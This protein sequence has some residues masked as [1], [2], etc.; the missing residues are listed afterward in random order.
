MINEPV[1]LTIHLESFE[2]PLD[3]LLHLIKELKIDIFDIPM[4][5]I[6]E[7][8][9]HYLHTMQELQLD[10]AGDYLLMAATLLEIK[11][12]MLLP[13]KELEIE[14]DFYEEGED[15]RE[16]LVNQ[17]LEY[18]R[19][20]E[21][22]KLLKEMEAERGDFFTKLPTDLEEYRHSIP[23]TPGEVSAPD[24]LYA[25]QKMFHRLQKMQPLHARVGQEEISVEKTMENILH[26]FREYAGEPFIRIPFTDFFEIPSKPQIVNTFLAML[27]LVRERK[28]R[29]YQEALYGEIL[30]EQ[31]PGDEDEY[32]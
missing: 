1:T 31:L 9:L 28:I 5:Q 11:S 18:K 29:F 12:R 22:A 30:L 8:Y 17:L 14:E 21:A 27:E 7:Q 16:E 2:G 25:L 23:L 19:V 15:P 4:T 24:L 10:I 32:E 20:Q 13:K 3:L 26:R 6:T